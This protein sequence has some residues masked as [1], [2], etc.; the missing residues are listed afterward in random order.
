MF[1]QTQL[2]EIHKLFPIVITNT[3][4]GYSKSQK[5]QNCFIR[6]CIVECCWRECDDDEKCNF[7]K[8]G[9]LCEYCWENNPHKSIIVREILTETYVKFG[10]ETLQRLELVFEPV[11]HLYD[12]ILI[13]VLD[14]PDCVKELLVVGANP[15]MNFGDISGNP[16]YT[17]LSWCFSTSNQ[18]E[19][20]A[21]LLMR[22]S[23][24]GL[25]FRQTDCYGQNIFG[26]LVSDILRDS[27]G[28]Y[29]SE[30]KRLLEL[31]MS[32]GSYPQL[33]SLNKMGI[34]GIQYEDRP[35]KQ[36][37]IDWLVSLEVQFDLDNCINPKCW[38]E[39]SC[40]SSKKK[41]L[42]NTRLGRYLIQLITS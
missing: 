9:E 37:I 13:Q 18:Y 28:S 31:I 24:N 35:H 36:K 21:I 8:Y 15:N 11:L 20:S 1:S 30:Y 2:E 7:C 16:N 25:I 42:C 5:C 17:L 10:L 39:C 14:K 4:M 40:V 23:K 3:D 41:L 19:E 29:Q 6:E 32:H 12:K 26:S 33:E 22:A 34:S 27:V 38:N